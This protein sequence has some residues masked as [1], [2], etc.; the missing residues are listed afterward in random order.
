MSAEG[1]PRPRRR[2]MVILGAAILGALVLLL[3]MREFSR[4]RA[5]AAAHEAT[6]AVHATAPPMPAGAASSAPPSTAPTPPTSPT[7]PTAPTAPSTTANPG[8]SPLPA[9]AMA[10][11]APAE[12]VLPAEPPEAPLGTLDREVIRDTVRE[13]MP[14]LRF[15]FEWQLE[16]H[17][18][19]AGHVSMAWR[20]AE[21]GT[22]EE[23]SVLEDA[24]HDDTVLRCFRGVIGRLTFPAPEGGP[25][26]VHY[27]FTLSNAPEARRPEGI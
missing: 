14:F 19:L 12:G 20:I 13:A 16:Q 21:D 10:T 27:P 1:A 4:R 18:E 8:A 23:P 2:G 15:C 24:L 25:V 3:S 11:A 6:P 7:T 22:V 5:D 17:P 26:V 9:P